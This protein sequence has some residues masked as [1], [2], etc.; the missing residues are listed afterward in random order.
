[1]TRFWY[2]PGYPCLANCAS[3]PAHYLAETSAAFCRAPAKGRQAP[4]ALHTLAEHRLTR[5][6]SIMSRRSAESKPREPQAGGR[7]AKMVCL[8]L[9]PSW[10]ANANQNGARV[11]RRRRMEA[12]AIST[13]RL[14]CAS[15]F[16]VP[17]SFTENFKSL[18]WPGRKAHPPPPACDSNTRQG[19]PALNQGSLMTDT[20]H[21]ARLLG[22][23]RGQANPG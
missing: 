6:G 19:V 16:R 11:R 3:R 8:A 7:P 20:P 17:G 14:S 9:L 15:K 21:R 22:P 4:H 2:A 1:M 23:A 18:T 13:S 5:S 12:C 10:D